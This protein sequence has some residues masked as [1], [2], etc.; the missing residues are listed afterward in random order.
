MNDSNLEVEGISDQQSDKNQTQKAQNSINTIER[1]K[2]L[3]GF[4]QMQL[5]LSERNKG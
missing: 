1:K 2:Y 4:K 3:R 5:E